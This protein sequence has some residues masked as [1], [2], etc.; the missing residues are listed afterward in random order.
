V[1]SS[2]GGGADREESVNKKELIGEGVQVCG[3]TESTLSGEPVI[4]YDTIADQRGTS[5]LSK[6][7]KSAFGRGKA[8]KEEGRERDDSKELGERR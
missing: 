5:R 6:T 8:S 7:L 2:R 3:M 1:W 4:F